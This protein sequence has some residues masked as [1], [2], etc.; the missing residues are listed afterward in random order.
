MTKGVPINPPSTWPTMLIA[1]TALG[2]LARGRLLAIDVVAASSLVVFDL[3][4]NKGLPMAAVLLKAVSTVDEEWNRL[5]C[6]VSKNS[7]DLEVLVD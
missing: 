7:A 4:E 1:M 6:C 5:D 3:V 2:E